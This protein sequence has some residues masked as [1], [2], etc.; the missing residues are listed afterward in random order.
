M[1]VNSFSELIAA[2]EAIAWREPK[3]AEEF[4]AL[5]KE[6]WEIMQFIQTNPFGNTCPSEIWHF[7][8]DTDI[9]FKDKIY[10]EYQRPRF[11]AA[12]KEWSDHE[13]SNPSFKRDALKR[14]P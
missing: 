1:S 7:L 4:T 12:I 8:T 6:C 13:Q 11:I 5:E 10:T 14:A 9:R 3:T 2:L